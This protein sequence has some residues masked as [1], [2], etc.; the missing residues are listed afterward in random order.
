VI[1]PVRQPIVSVLGHVDHGKTTILD[2]IRGTTVVEREAGR[3]TQHIGATEVPLEAIKRVCGKL[4]EGMKITVPG[5]LFIDTPGHHSF[6]TLRARGGSLA[7]LAVLVIDVAEGLKPQTI[8]S[9]RILKRYKTPFVIAANKID[10]LQYWIPQRGKAFIESYQTQTDEAKEELDNR[11]YDLI[12]DLYKQGFTADRYDRIR[13]F[14]KTVAIVPTCAVEGEGIPDLLLVLVGLAQKFLEE[15]LET[16]E[17][18]AEGTVLEVKEERGFGKTVDV[19]IHRGTLRKGDPIAIGTPHGPIKTR[20]RGM[21]KPRPLDEIRDPRERF[22]PVDEVSAAAGVKILAP[23]LEGVVSGAPLRSLRG[24]SE[25]EAEAILQSIAEEMSIN[26][27]L[28]EEGEEG[29][30]IKAD[31]IGSVEGLAYELREAGIPIKRA[32]TGD[33]SRRDVVEF[34]TGKDPLLRVILAFNVK[35]YPEAREEAK[36]LGVEIFEGDVIYRIVEDYLEWR[37]SKR[38]ELDSMSRGEITYPGKFK[39]LPGYVFRQSKPAVVGVRVLAGR[40]RKGQRILREDGRVVGAIKSIQVEGRSVDEAKTGE[41]VAIAID[42]VTVGRQINV[43]DVLYID[44]PEGDV[45]K[46]RDV[47][48]NYDEKETLE[49]TIQIKRKVEPFW[50]M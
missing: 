17:G 16:E 12:G 14:T 7:D 40:I 43:E 41:E 6:T 1:L 3:I 46:L 18:P 20:V 34:G 30:M 19:I 31:A 45:K 21:M 2:Y 29:V 48:L 22:F 44:I 50:G 42:G 10:R 15:H 32:E 11:I 4:V 47:E 5:L 28:V 24:M 8:E 9:I 25:E 39:I 26:V 33:V 37:E 35:V 38:V 13:D 27:E 49:Q 23:D 36:N